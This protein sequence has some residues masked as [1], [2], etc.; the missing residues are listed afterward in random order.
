[1]RRFYLEKLVKDKVFLNMQELKQKV[2]YRKLSDKEFLLALQAKLLEEAKEFDLHDPKAANELADLLE[3][4]EQI[5]VTIG[6]DFAELREIQR[7]R[8]NERGKFDK[9]IY[10]EYLELNDEDPWVKY[11]AAEPERFPERKT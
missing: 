11:Y 7:K 9:K 2:T 10:I 6:K 3:V 4:V 5:G 8:R 1:M